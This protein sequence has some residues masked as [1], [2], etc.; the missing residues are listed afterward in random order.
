MKTN[1]P[2]LVEIGHTLA[3]KTLNNRLCGCSQRSV[4]RQCFVRE[5]RSSSTVV[6]SVVSRAR[7]GEAE[8]NLIVRRSA[9][10]TVLLLFRPTKQCTRTFFPSASCSRICRHRRD[11]VPTFNSSVRA[12]SSQDAAHR[13]SLMSTQIFSSRARIWSIWSLLCSPKMGLKRSI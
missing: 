5:R 6:R 3:E 10:R 11:R 8:A 13:R 12:P 7:D 9:A 1:L 4:P 2:D